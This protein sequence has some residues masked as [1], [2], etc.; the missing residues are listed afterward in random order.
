MAMLDDSDG[1]QRRTL[2]VVLAKCLGEFSVLSQ[3]EFARF[4]VLPQLWV[5]P[6][7]GPM[8][9]RSVMPDE[10]GDQVPLIDPLSH[11]NLAMTPG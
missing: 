4:L 1:Q 2:L 10:Y 5:M 3:S 7:H 6:S 11:K 8:I 9:P